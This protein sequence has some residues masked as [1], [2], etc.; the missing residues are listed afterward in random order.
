MATIYKWSQDHNQAVMHRGDWFKPF[1]E[2]KKGNWELIYPDIEDIRGLNCMLTVKCLDCGAVFMRDAYHWLIQGNQNGCD[3]C[4]RRRVVAMKVKALEAQGFE[5]VS[6]EKTRHGQ[7]I[8]TMRC[9]NCGLVFEQ[10]GKNIGRWIKNGSKCMACLKNVA[11]PKSEDK[12]PPDAVRI[13]KACIESRTTYSELAEKVH[14]SKSRVVG[15]A[16]GHHY[17]QEVAKLIADA[18]EEIARRKRNDNRP[19]NR[20]S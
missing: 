3:N 1:W 15:I 19:S 20:P 13:R 7:R 4:Y 5:V 8:Y 9:R 12:L 6:A 2:S 18:A 11:S 14:Y 10:Y 17:S 16:Q